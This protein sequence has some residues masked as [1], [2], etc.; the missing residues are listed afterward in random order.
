MLFTWT[1]ELQG[2]VNMVD[3]LVTQLHSRGSSATRQQV[4]MNGGRSVWVLSS[5]VYMTAG[6]NERR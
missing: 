4:R 1:T 3:D 5:L 6:E 2:S